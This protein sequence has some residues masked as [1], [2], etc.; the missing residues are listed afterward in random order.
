MA[1][2]SRGAR[3]AIG[4][5]ARVRTTKRKRRGGLEQFSQQLQG[6]R[7][8][9]GPPP[10][11]RGP[12]PSP[13]R[14][15]TPRERE[16]AAA[17]APRQTRI[18]RP[19]SPLPRSLAR[20]SPSTVFSSGLSPNYVPPLIFPLHSVRLTAPPFSSSALSTVRRKSST[21]QLCG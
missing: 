16:G 6:Q 11:T 17:P 21:N 20:S 12:S 8:Y 5:R 1:V 14:T 4:R 3:H 9:H 7:Q 15:V 13:A 2:G 18:T 10:P 19:L